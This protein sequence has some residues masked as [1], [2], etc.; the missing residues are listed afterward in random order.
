MP[1][2]ILEEDKL[3]WSGLPEA[4]DLAKPMESR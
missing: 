1:L 4:L 2:S 3:L